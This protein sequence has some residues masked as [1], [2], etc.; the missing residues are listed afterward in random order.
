MPNITGSCLIMS[1]NG[2]LKRRNLTLD[3]IIILNVHSGK[4]W[5]VVLSSVDISIK[6]I[7][8]YCVNIDIADIKF[9]VIS[10]YRFFRYIAFPI[11][12][13]PDISSFSIYRFS[14]IS[15]SRYIEFLDISFSP[16]YRVRRCNIIK[17]HDIQQRFYS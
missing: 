16:I 3:D 9:W 15:L 8:R 17:F 14:D 5:M 6:S 1:K 13:F 10:I 12:R 7:Y 2:S 4:V 11:Y